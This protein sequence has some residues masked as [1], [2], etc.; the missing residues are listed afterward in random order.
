M[1]T[2]EDSF[3]HCATF[4]LLCLE[5][6]TVY[7][8]SFFLRYTQYHPIPPV[9]KDSYVIENDIYVRI[10]WLRLILYHWFF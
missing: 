7:D 8:M 5:N 3:D 6:V 4:A 1:S 10:R 2:S 9:E